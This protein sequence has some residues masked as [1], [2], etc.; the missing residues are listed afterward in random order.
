ML[1]GRLPH[2]E[3]K[4]TA[5]QIADILRTKGDTVEIIAPDRPVSAAVALLVQHRIGALV[6]QAG[7][8]VVGII[9]ERDILRLADKD[10]AR[11]AEIPVSR[12]MTRELVVGVPDDDIMYVMEILTKNRI[13]HLPIV[14]GGRLVGIVSIGDVVN[15]VRS[16]LE[17]ENRYLRE[18]VQGVF[19]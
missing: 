2:E 5:M 15:A 1:C 11:L 3:R 19:A 4:E 7:D 8:E 14:A 13:R 9:S 17:A 12:V 10:A 18:Y 6:V 16:G